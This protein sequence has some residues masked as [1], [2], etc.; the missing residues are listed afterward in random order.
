VE[1]LKVL[2]V[3]NDHHSLIFDIYD[4]EELKCLRGEKDDNHRLAGKN[5]YE[6]YFNTCSKISDKDFD[7]LSVIDNLLFYSDEIMYFTANIFLVQPFI[8]D[9]EFTK[10]EMGGN[11]IYPYDS[12]MADKR[13]NMFTEIVFEKLYS[14]WSQIA[15]ILKGYF[16]PNLKNKQF[17]FSIIIE[18][19]AKLNLNS[20]NFNWLHNFKLNDYKDFNDRRKNIVHI[21]SFDTNYRNAFLKN[22]SKPHHLKKVIDERNNIPL[23]F[24]RHIDLSIIGF[25]KTLNL[26]TKQSV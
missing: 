17:N 2:T 1:N 5:I 4:K 11:I 24:K 20:E 23:F 8:C 14:Y 15:I 13:Y 25:E 18:E 3:L 9:P 10:I 7:K 19:L 6:W 21:Q 22:V 12:N 16:A 26:I